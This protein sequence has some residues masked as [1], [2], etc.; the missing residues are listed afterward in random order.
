[1][2]PENVKNIQNIYKI[3]VTKS[4]LK[5]YNGK[6]IRLGTSEYFYFLHHCHQFY[7]HFLFFYKYNFH[8]HS[9]E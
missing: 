5:F 6:G 4:V 2:N 3:F 8:L 9:I 1:M 7:N